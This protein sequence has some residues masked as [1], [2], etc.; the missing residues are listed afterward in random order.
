M[1]T[2]RFTFS[3]GAIRE[4]SL[5]PEAPNALRLL[6]EGNS[7]VADLEAL[8]DLVVIEVGAPPA[9]LNMSD[10]GVAER[11]LLDRV[12][13]EIGI[14]SYPNAELSA[15][16]VAAQLIALSRSARVNGEFL[17]AD[18]VTRHIRLRTDFGAVTRAHP[19]SSSQEVARPNTVA[20]VVAVAA[21]AAERA[22]PLVIQ[23]LPLAM[24]SL[25]S[26]SSSVRH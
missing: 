10:P 23:G 24:E 25:G 1:Q 19:V 3:P 2:T 13:A 7:T 22:Q 15:V 17:A 21:D 11:F 4:W 16:A 20:E 12:R 6:R 26:A 8:R 9:T 18:T 14:G 5:Q